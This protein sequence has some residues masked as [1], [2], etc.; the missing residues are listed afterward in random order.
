MKT[1]LFIFTI[2]SFV[3]LLSF[4][5]D[6]T[7]SKNNI[8]IVLNTTTI[9]PKDTSSVE[10]NNVQCYYKDGFV[11]ILF[12]SYEGKVTSTIT[13][14]GTDEGQTYS[15]SSLYPIQIYVSQQPASYEIYIST[16]RNSYIGYFTIE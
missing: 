10:N 5:K 16:S 9:R 13:N 6:E 4:G 8:E 12:D 15:A 7:T 3:F 11:Y 1:K 14:L 2:F